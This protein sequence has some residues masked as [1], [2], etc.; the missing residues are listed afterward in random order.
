MK[1]RIGLPLRLTPGE[2][3]EAAVS[4]PTKPG[5]LDELLRLPTCWIPA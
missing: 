1:T 5:E 4:L 2:R 3:L